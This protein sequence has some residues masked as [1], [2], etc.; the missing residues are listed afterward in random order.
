LIYT[1]LAYLGDA[2]IGG[3]LSLIGIALAIASYFWR[4]SK[5]LLNFTK[6]E[7]YLAVKRAKS[8]LKGDLEIY[9]KG[10]PVP[11]VSS[12]V[13]IV[14]NAGNTLLRDSDIA[15][16]D[17]LRFELPN[18]TDLLSHSIWK[19]SRTVN[20]VQLRPNVV[21][22]TCCIEITFDFL[23]PNEGFICDIVHTARR[24]EIRMAGTILGS[25]QSPAPQTNL[26]SLS[27]TR[28]GRLAR[29]IS[30]VL[31]MC[32]GMMFFLSNF[33]P[34]LRDDPPWLIELY[35]YTKTPVVLNT[36]AVVC[37]A[38]ALGLALIGPRPVPQDLRLPPE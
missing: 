34:W 23:E 17:R 35:N 33:V 5:V 25:R 18:G 37:F 19:V 31:M 21:N 11:F 9:F 6:R 22:D 32:M 36:L 1:I 7:T 12:T 14:W 29:V 3:I 10:R 30:V 26:S 15:Q 24:D 27:A 8:P 2:R 20:N 13:F 38:I 28:E 4:R 16:T